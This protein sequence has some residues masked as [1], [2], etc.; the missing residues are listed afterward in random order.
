MSG[1]A[2]S[3]TAENQACPWCSESSGYRVLTSRE[4]MR[5]LTRT[6]L[7]GI[8]LGGFHAFGLLLNSAQQDRRDLDYFRGLMTSG[9][10]LCCQ[11]CGGVVRVC[12]GCRAVS[13]WI[14]SDVHKCG[15][16]G[17]VFV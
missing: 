11:A 12:P 13:E 16:C 6:F 3:I 7:E 2:T 1:R 5:V 8:Y 4:S 9:K 17:T 14:N 15:V 10:E